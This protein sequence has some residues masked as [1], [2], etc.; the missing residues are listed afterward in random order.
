MSLGAARAGFDVRAAVDLDGVVLDAHTTNFPNAAHLL[1]DVKTLTGKQVRSLVGARRSNGFG[2]IGGPPCQGFSC[3]GRKSAT[4]PR[5]TLFTHFFR[6]VDEAR[7]LFFL[8]ENVPG[9]LHPCNR[10]FIE[11]ALALVAD[12]YS[13][14][15]PARVRASDF[16]APTARERVFVLGVLRRHAPHL[17]SCL[18]KP[19]SVTPVYVREALRGL[20]RRIHPSWLTADQGWRKVDYSG[21]TLFA[22]R[23]SGIVPHGVG[24]EHSLR[25]LRRTSEVSGNI[26]TRHSKAQVARYAV[27]R[28]GAMDAATKSRRLEIDGYCPTLRAGT[29]SD[30]GRFQA[31]RPLHPTQDRVI[32]PREAARLQGFPDWFQ[33]S[34]TKW[35]SFRMIGNSV[36]PIV[37]ERLLKRLHGAL[38]KKQDD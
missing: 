28:P 7:P 21:H 22:K 17:S 34:H 10:D 25:R 12:S 33:F 4:D 18:D 20:P 14:V 5:N 8:A 29:G 6:L 3:I 36:S 37:A 27:V 30:K 26:A 9:I 2:M 19:R 31:V 15:G 13:I 35:H 24:C 16:G 32:T 38:G 11:P 23:A 1:A